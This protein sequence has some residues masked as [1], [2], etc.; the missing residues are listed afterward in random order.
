MQGKL[1]ESGL[2]HSGK[3]YA[4]I[5]SLVA[6]CA[7]ASD[8]APSEFDFRSLVSALTDNPTESVATCYLAMA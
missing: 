2:S 3:P 8:K 1:L 4:N 6:S 5:A 7:E